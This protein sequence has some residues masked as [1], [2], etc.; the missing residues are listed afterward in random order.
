[1]EIVYA[2]LHRNIPKE[3]FAGADNGSQMGV[4]N[5]LY[6]AQS[7]NNLEQSFDEYLRFGLEAGI[8]FF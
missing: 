6:E 8:T 3:I 1:M 2:Q 5:Q 4:F 7:I